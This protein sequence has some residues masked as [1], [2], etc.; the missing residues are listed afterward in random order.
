[1]A[2]TQLDLGL[3]LGLPKDAVGVNGRV[4]FR[5]LDGNRAVFVDLDPFYCYPLD[6]VVLHRFCA[7]QLV[8]AGLVKVR[9]VC[10][11][12]G[13]HDR[14]FSRYRSSFRKQGIAGLV[15]GKVGRKTIRTGSLAAGVVKRYQRG[16]S[17]SDIAQEMGISPSTV[18]RVPRDEGVPLRG[19]LEQRGV[20]RLAVE[21]GDPASE[22]PDSAEWQAAGSQPDRSQTDRSQADGSQ[23]D[24]AQTN[25]PQA[26]P[27]QADEPQADE[28]QADGPQTNEPQTV[29]P[30][31][32]EATSI[33][34][35]PPLDR[36]ATIV[37]WI[38]EAPV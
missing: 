32:V 38:E 7:I 29:E 24:G 34:Y 22:G 8:E 15:P 2:S 28:P 33:P 5:D 17:T 35:A 23:A 1:M 19:A 11:A 4:W 12:F 18:R 27:P 26:D 36:L 14:A 13:I 10:A 3:G 20:L 25:E 21:D 30:P 9:E 37:G 31:I 16:K 6:D